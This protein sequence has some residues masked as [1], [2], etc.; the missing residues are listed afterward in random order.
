MEMYEEL[1]RIA[2]MKQPEGR[3]EG[4]ST[5]GLIAAKSRE[6]VSSTIWLYK[7]GLLGFGQKSKGLPSFMLSL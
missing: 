7:I 3:W 5:I 6:C 2:D 4:A 1:L